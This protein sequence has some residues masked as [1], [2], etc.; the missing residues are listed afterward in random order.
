MF[1]DNRDLAAL[2]VSSGEAADGS[3]VYR[4]MTDSMQVAEA[5]RLCSLL[6]TDMVSCVL[7]SRS[8]TFRRAATF[9]MI[10]AYVPRRAYRPR[11]R[12]D[13]CIAERAKTFA[14]TRI[15]IKL[16]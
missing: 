16:S 4:I 14:P 10:N 6:W 7:E 5:E 2:I 9:Q 3:S 13:P 1:P 8:L 12:S 11:G 15:F